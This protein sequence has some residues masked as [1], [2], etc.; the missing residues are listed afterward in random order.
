MSS[1]KTQS[2]PP[3]TGDEHDLT[4]GSGIIGPQPRNMPRSLKIQTL[5]CGSKNVTYFLF[6]NR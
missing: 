3:E 1:M 2:Q 6:Y 5:K 4:R